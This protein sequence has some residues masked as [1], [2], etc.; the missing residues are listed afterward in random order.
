M[1]TAGQTTPPVP[2]SRR[3]LAPNAALEKAN[4]ALEEANVALEKAKAALEKEKA[5]LEK[6]KAA[7]EKEKAALEKAK[8]A[9]EVQTAAKADVQ[10]DLP[11]TVTERKLSA[12]VIKL[13]ASIKTKK[14]STVELR[15]KL[16]KL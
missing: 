13:I 1:G 4:V 10:K 11:K 2:R 6:A 7:F 8:A 16:R 3:R 5:A 12:V 14:L 15:K 9:L